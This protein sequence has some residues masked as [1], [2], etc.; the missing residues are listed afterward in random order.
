VSANFCEIAIRNR[1]FTSGD[2]ILT[3]N[4][5]KEVPYGPLALPVV[6]SQVS[7]PLQVEPTQGAPVSVDEPNPVNVILNICS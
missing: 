7:V 6:Q 2:Q 3:L 4:A 5:L 1:S